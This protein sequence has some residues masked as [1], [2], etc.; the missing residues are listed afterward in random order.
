MGEEKFFS[1]SVELISKQ[2]TNSGAGYYFGNIV[3]SSSNITGSYITVNRARED[4]RMKTFPSQVHVEHWQQPP[5][6]KAMEDLCQHVE[7]SSGLDSS[8]SEALYFWGGGFAMR[9]SWWNN[10]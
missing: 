7:C 2:Q 9:L 8:L 4:T 1:K 6:Q 5:I 3:C 10:M